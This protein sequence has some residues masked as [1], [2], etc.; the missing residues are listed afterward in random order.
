MKILLSILFILLIL[1]TTGT[2]LYFVWKRKEFKTLFVQLGIIGGAVIL[3]IITI[4]E[5]DPPS[6]SKLLNTLSPFG[7]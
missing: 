3:G 6:F 5:L 4:Y 7:T 1:V 2:H